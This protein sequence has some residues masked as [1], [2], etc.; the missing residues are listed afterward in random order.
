MQNAH[1]LTHNSE[2]NALYTQSSRKYSG[3]Q[4]N[5]IKIEYMGSV[6]GVRHTEKGWWT[7]IAMPW[8]LFTSDFEWRGHTK[9]PV[10]GNIIVVQCIR[11]WRLLKHVASC[12]TIT[13]LIRVGFV[14][15]TSSYMRGCCGEGTLLA[16]RGTRQLRNEQLKGC[17]AYKR[18]YRLGQNIFQKSTSITIAIKHLIVF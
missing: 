3:K 1:G 5:M 13:R 8:R 16:K 6:N 7:Q 15:M 18:R 14:M 11:V 10:V 9:E 17:T 2:Y 4:K 12:Q